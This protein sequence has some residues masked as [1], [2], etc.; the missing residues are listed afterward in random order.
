MA[1]LDEVAEKGN[2]LRDLV[3][4]YRCEGLDLLDEAW[5]LA[6]KRPRS[7]VFTGMGTSEYVCQVLVQYLAEKSPVP[8]CYWEAGELLHYGL[9]SIRDDD[10]VVA[11]SQSGESI[12][13][14]RVTEHLQRHRRLIAVT[15]D[16]ESYMARH[17]RLNLPMLAG[18]E[19]SISN[20]TYTNSMAVLLLLGRALVGEDPS[21]TLAEL[22]HVADQ[23][24][25]FLATRR[26]EIARAAEHLRD[27]TFLYFVARGPA[28][29]AARQAGLTYQEGVHLYTT[30]LPGGSF[31]H[32]PFEIVGPGHYA[33][34]YA[35]D[36]H[37]GDLVRKMAVEVAEMG[38]KVLLFT[39]E[40]VQSSSS[41]MTIVISPGAPELFPLAT[42]V[43]QEL[44]LYRMAADRGVEAGVFRRGSKVTTKE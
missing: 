34:M 44:L 17:A 3:R 37:G 26:D 36:G 42:A 32:G 20:K 10:V 30:V 9:E 18:Q 39:S 28:L 2:V 33:V 41:L 11:V 1:F 19:A 29:A 15:N 24:D 27:A 31:R 14:R 5:H 8:V 25:N 4:F 40:D 35:P 16:S 7:F 38:S 12:E 6:S 23:M 13:T 22:E 21:P 43:P